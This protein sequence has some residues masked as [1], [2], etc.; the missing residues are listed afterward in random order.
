MTVVSPP[1]ERV[2][3]DHDHGL[4]LLRVY[5]KHNLPAAKLTPADPGRSADLT[6]AGIPDPSTNEGARNAITE[7]QARL[8][9]AYYQGA[10]EDNLV[11]PLHAAFNA[12]ELR[13]TEIN[14][15]H[16]L[17]SF[18]VDHFSGYLASS[19]RCDPRGREDDQ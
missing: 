6:L 4:A 10:P 5:G 17:M 13:L 8:V 7:V 15:T 14:N 19:G 1:S 11:G 2:S 16:T 18:K 3:V 9:G 12:K